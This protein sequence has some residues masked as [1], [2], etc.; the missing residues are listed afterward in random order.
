MSTQWLH[1][2]QIPSYETDAVALRWLNGSLYYVLKNRELNNPTA[3]FSWT[4]TII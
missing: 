2:L 3:H 1:K 4:I